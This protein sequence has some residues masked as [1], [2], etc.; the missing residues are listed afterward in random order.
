MKTSTIED[1]ESEVEELREK[2]E[3]LESQVYTLE[4]QCKGIEIGQ[5]Q[6]WESIDAAFGSIT[7]LKE[8]YENS[9]N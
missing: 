3:N 8:K 4:E 2:N 7:N 9:N 6:I 5:C 1:L